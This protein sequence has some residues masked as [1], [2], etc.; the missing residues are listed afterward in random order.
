MA[1]GR[2]RRLTDMVKAVEQG[3][4]QILHM[5][6][7]QVTASVPVSDTKWS[8]LETERHIRALRNPHPRQYRLKMRLSSARRGGNIILRTE[9]L[10]VGY[11]GVAL[12]ETADI[13]LRRHQIVALIGDNGTGKTT[14]LRTVMG[15]LDPLAGEVRLGANL[16]V[17]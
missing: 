8:V 2:L 10:Q 13:E 15:K 5:D 1:Q 4:A 3:G 16:D 12:F 6:W 7:S 17:G 11:P 14:F 9:G